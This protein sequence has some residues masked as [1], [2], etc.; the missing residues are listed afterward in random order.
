MQ[1]PKGKPPERTDPGAYINITRAG[2]HLTHLLCRFNKNVKRLSPWAARTISTV[3]TT[4]L[5]WAKW[6][7]SERISR[8]VDALDQRSGGSHD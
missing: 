6:P 8:I 4:A 3:I 5:S 7:W 1:W 2:G